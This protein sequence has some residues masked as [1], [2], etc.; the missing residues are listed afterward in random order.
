MSVNRII[1]SFGIYDK[2]T[3]NPSLIRKPLGA[4]YK[5]AKDT[6]PNATVHI[7]LINCSEDLPQIYKKNITQINTIIKSMGSFI[8]RLDKTLFKTLPDGI[9]WTPDTAQEL[10]DH[11]WAFLGYARIPS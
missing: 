3:T 4:L 11:W 7:P 9:R 10:L 6:F 5:A 1:L 8:P 2:G